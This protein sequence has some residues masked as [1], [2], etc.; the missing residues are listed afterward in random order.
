M[1]YFAKESLTCES[2]VGLVAGS[3]TRR[4]HRKQWGVE[5]GEER[6]TLFPSSAAPHVARTTAEAHE[7]IYEAAER[8]G[9][10]A[11]EFE[12]ESESDAASIG[13]AEQKRELLLEK[14]SSPFP[15]RPGFTADAITVTVNGT[16]HV[17]SQCETVGPRTSLAEWLRYDLGL[18]GT[19]IG[20]HEGGCGA[21]GDYSV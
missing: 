11:A 3:H 18:C 19:K 10:V 4:Y 7:L 12:P 9:W 14:G 16:A 6:G 15:G 20:C 17:L 5:N 2:K 1:S 8:E 21:V 13:G